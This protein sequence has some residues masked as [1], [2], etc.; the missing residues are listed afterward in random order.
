MELELDLEL[1]PPHPPQKIS[2]QEFGIDITRGR[3]EIATTFG[4][5]TGTGSG[6]TPPQPKIFIIR[7]WNRH[8][9][10]NLKW[11]WN[12]NWNSPDPNKFSL[13]TCE[14]NAWPLPG[15]KVG[16][17][18]RGACCAIS[19]TKP[20]RQRVTVGAWVAL[21]GRRLAVSCAAPGHPREL[22]AWLLIW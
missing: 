17:R 11:I 5:R 2:P 22:A 3:F 8:Y 7:I 21:A 1:D 6:T 10:W 18:G 15:S 9:G 12:W 4:T 16:F 13:V 19:V 14:V 20:H